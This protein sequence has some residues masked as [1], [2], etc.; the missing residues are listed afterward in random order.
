MP[1]V[2]QW[3]RVRS[4]VNCSVRRGAWYEVLRLTPDAAVLEV[5]QRSVS[6]PRALLQVVA[7]RPKRW[8]VVPR[9]YDAVDL[10]L[11]WGSRYAVC[12]ECRARMPLRREQREMRC[13]ACSGM[14]PIAWDERTS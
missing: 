12:P 1:E 4:D 10:P 2:P 13:S 6:V 5:G 3:A 11:S 8:S 7:I 14:F 9:P